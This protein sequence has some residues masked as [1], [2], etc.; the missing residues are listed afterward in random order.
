LTEVWCEAEDDVVL[1]YLIKKEEWF[2]FVQVK[3]NDLKQAWRVPKLCDRE[4][5]RSGGG[6]GKC[7]VE[8]SLAHDRAKEK[9]RFRV[10]TRWN[11]D[12]VL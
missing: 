11:P 10:V 3:G 1:V 12:G 2:E 9:C 6:P 8:K 5:P 4:P 7:I